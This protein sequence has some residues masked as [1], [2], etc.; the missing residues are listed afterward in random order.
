[1]A[2]YRAT[3]DGNIKLT[4]AE[5]AEIRAEWEKNDNEI[6]PPTPKSLEQRIAECE[7]EVAK[8]KAK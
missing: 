4:D 6:K 8:L 1:M 7:A 5:E 3:K 2:L